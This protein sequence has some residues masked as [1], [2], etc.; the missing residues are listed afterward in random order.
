MTSAL[1]LSRRNVLAGTGALVMSFASSPT[2]LVRAAEG[3][4]GQAPPLPGSLKQS[5]YLD[6]WIRIAADGRVTV[7][8]GKAELGQGLK[9]ALLQISRP[10]DRSII[11]PIYL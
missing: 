4:A 6:S 7:L 5:P 10:S 11:E 1:V 8:T 3:D 2:L 9:T